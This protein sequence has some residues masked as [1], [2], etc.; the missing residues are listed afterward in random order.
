MTLTPVRVLS[1]LQKCLLWVQRVLAAR[2][3]RR[4]FKRGQ[5]PT[6]AELHAGTLKFRRTEWTRHPRGAR[7][8]QSAPRIVCRGGAERDLSR[9]GLEVKVTVLEFQAL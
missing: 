6:D 9:I 5:H 3:N 8:L 4:T 7:A 2:A 1:A